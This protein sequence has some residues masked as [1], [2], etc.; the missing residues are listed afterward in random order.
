MAGRKIKVTDVARTAGVSA[1]TVDRVLNNRFGVKPET[2]KRVEEAMATLGYAS[3]SL[4][5]R[6]A[7]PIH[8]IDVVLPKGTNSFFALLREEIERQA[9]RLSEFG[10]R[11]RI[12]ETDVFDTS[13]IMAFLRAYQPL[14]GRTLVIVATDA[15]EVRQ[16]IDALTKQGVTV[17]T[18]VSDNAR[19]RRNAFIGI[20]NFAAGRT[21]GALMARALGPRTGQIGILVGHL[22]LRDHLDRRSGFEQVMADLKPDCEI[23]LLGASRDDGEVAATLTRAAVQ[24]HAD[25]VGIYNTGGGNEGLF[26]ALRPL[27][28]KIRPAVICH[29][30]T[31]ATRQALFDG[32]CDALIT[33]DISELARRALDAATGTLLGLQF[34]DADAHMN[35]GIMIKENLPWAAA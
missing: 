7:P 1:S 9:K 8:G 21:A 24:K 2:T 11:I 10:T 6:M 17:V 16:E 22:A 25:F 35:I 5:A 23:R 28:A 31:P 33:R 30:L 19:S 15:P 13:S 3:N 27:T 20:D 12:S 14:A 26:R 29:E 4:A 32:T 34:A 18:L